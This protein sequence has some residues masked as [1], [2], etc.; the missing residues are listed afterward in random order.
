MEDLNFLHQKGP[1]SM[2]NSVFIVQPF[3]NNQIIEDMQVPKFPVWFQVWGLPLEY[4][5]RSAAI[6]FGNIVGEFGE[7]EVDEAD[8]HNIRFLRVRAIIDPALP[9]IMGCHVNFSEHQDQQT[10]NW[11][12]FRYERIFRICCSCGRIGYN[13]NQ[14]DWDD[15]LII[16]GLEVHRAHLL[17][18][19]GSDF[20]KDFNFPMVSIGTFFFLHP[21]MDS[22]LNKYASGRSSRIPISS[23][24]LVSLER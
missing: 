19:F 16:H 8:L 11:I 4:F 9:L 2:E 13:E 12:Q 7:C 15:Q 18:R 6:I 23:S 20:V 22:T 10:T 5:T 17:A 3:R 21:C 24:P 14:C 1:W